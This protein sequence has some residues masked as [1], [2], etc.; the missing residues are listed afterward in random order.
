MPGFFQDIFSGNF[1][2]A[3]NSPDDFI[4]DI[5]GSNT[6]PELLGGAALVAAPFVLPEIGAGIGAL[7]ADIGG[8]LG[9]G[10]EAAADTSLGA[11]NAFDL[12]TLGAGVDA[13]GGALGSAAL[14][15]NATLD[16]L[17]SGA[18][19]YALPGSAAD[20]ANSDFATLGAG[21]NATG[22]AL[23]TAAGA[24]LNLLS[25]SAAAGTTGAGAAA[26]GGGGILSSI[27]GAL[28]PISS[29][30]KTV[31]PVIGAAGLG[32]NLYSG[33]EQ[34]QALNQLNQ[35]EA[36]N[37]AQEQQTA[38]TENAA[39]APLLNSGQTLM[40][41]LQTGTLPPQFQSQ[42]DQSVAAAKA[43]IIQGY[44]S[45][46]MSS[47]PNQNSALAQDLA[48]VDQQALTLKG[49]L[50]STLST[51]GNQ[52]VTTAN[53]LL[54][55]GLSATNMSAELPIE[56][57]KLNSSLNQ[58]MAQSVSSFAAALNGSGVKSNTATL[59]LPTNLIGSSGNTN[60]G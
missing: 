44:A 10:G 5:G 58:S 30:L 6:L 57:A 36:A 48:N 17:T 11:A 41:Y 37:V 56:V 42:V 47:D 50:E 49:N 1:A 35:Q 25:G 32:Y 23:D 39:A 20:L 45:R 14:P 12:S 8:T 55:S 34:K 60:L 31:A 59:T 52:M 26:G 53:A 13:S 4:K 29:A 33:Y 19:G 22:G 9:L 18:G 7:G 2:K 51:A 24:P 3:F 54:S 28:S 27:T 16:A 38:A 46:G 40:T 21:V 43:Q 15:A